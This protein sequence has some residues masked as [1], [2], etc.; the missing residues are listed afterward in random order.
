MTITCFDFEEARVS[1][2]CFV[3]FLEH[4]IVDMEKNP[5]RQNIFRDSYFGFLLHFPLTGWRAHSQIL[6]CRMQRHVGDLK[7]DVQGIKIKFTEID[8][9]LIMGLKFGPVRIDG[10]GRAEAG[11]IMGGRGIRETYLR[12]GSV[13][14][15]EL[16][17]AYLSLTDKDEHMDAV[18]LAL[19]ICIENL[20]VG[21][22]QKNNCVDMFIDMVDDLDYFNNYP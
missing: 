10:D 15:K 12:A 3:S 20:L 14:K 7:F 22:S 6:H 1:P 2:K 8:F 9:S 18:K 17:Q 5:D 13:S 16:K 21:S 11:R 4:M 19:I